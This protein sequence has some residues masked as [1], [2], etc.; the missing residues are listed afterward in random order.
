MEFVREDKF[1]GV[2]E[3]IEGSKRGGD[4]GVKG[5][6]VVRDGGMRTGSV[7]VVGRAE[8][9]SRRGGRE[10]AKRAKDHESGNMWEARMVNGVMNP[11]K[12]AMVTLVSVEETDVGEIKLIEERGM[13]GIV[14]ERVGRVMEVHVMMGNPARGMEFKMVSEFIGELGGN[15]GGDIRVKDEAIMKEGVLRMKDGRVG[16]GRGGWGKRDECAGKG[17]KGKTVGNGVWPG[18]SMTEGKGGMGHVGRARGATGGKL[19]GA[20]LDEG[21]VVSTEDLDGIKPRRWWI[22]R[23]K[24]QG[25]GGFI[26]RRIE[27]RDIMDSGA[28][29]GCNSSNGSVMMRLEGGE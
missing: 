18:I 15:I 9:M 6:T 13:D 7:K 28:E 3:G 26:C 27:G 22:K 21:E 8:G 24:G 5:P 2:K 14:C 17:E 29:L 1:K 10:G 16:D 23:I 4:G 11:S 19:M 20:D 25:K 12:G